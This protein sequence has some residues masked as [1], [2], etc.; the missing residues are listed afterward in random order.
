MCRRVSWLAVRLSSTTGAT[1]RWIRRLLLNVPSIALLT[2]HT[3]LFAVVTFH[4]HGQVAQMGDEV[5]E[6][7]WLEF[8]DVDVDA[9]FVQG[10]PQFMSAI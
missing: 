3:N 8:G 6:V 9:V 10:R 7:F 5:V 2:I 4:I 1:V